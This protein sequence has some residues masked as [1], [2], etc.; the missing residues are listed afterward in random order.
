MLIFC[1]HMF[2]IREES[3]ASIEENIDEYGD[4]YARDVTVEELNEVM[5]SVVPSLSLRLRRKQ[6]FNRMP[7]NFEPRFEA[8]T[9]RDELEQHGEG[10]EDLPGWMFE[11][12]VLYVVEYTAAGSRGSLRC[13]EGDVQ[14]TERLRVKQAVDT[15]RFAGAK[16]VHDVVDENVTHIVVGADRDRVKI[17]RKQTS[18]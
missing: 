8:Q 11:R 7:E 1:S 4:S 16:V 9:F 15:A 14:D 12:S 13:D 10:L 6:I 18:W 5:S 2:F 3:K 17:M